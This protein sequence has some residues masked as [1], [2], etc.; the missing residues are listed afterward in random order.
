[1]DVGEVLPFPGIG[2]G[3][4]EAAR[5]VDADRKF[6]ISPG[7]D[8]ETKAG[9]GLSFLGKDEHDGPIR[10]AEDAGERVFV[11]GAWSR[12]VAG[13]GVN[14]DAG[15]LVGAAAGVDLAVEIVGHRF[16]VEG[17]VYPRAGL[18]D[19]LQVFNEQRVVVR[20]DPEAADFGIAVITQEEQLRPRG[21]AKA[22]CRGPRRLGLGL[23]WPGVRFLRHL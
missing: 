16:I 22:E 1:M 13:V 17:D 2:I 19:E 6:D 14:P 12:R 18:L 4:R 7:A 3:A 10:A 21:R 8:V 20:G 5:V 23:R 15:E 11:G 9:V